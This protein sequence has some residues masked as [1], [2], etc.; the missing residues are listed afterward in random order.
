[1]TICEQCFKPVKYYSI[2]NNQ[3]LC[4]KCQSAKWSKGKAARKKAVRA[5]ESA[6][7]IQDLAD[8]W[9]SRNT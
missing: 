7:T 1:M 8:L 9:N 6:P 5:K 4:K 2:H 3:I